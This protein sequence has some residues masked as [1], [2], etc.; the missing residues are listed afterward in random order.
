MGAKPV[1]TSFTSGVINPSQL[2]SNLDI[3]AEAIADSL[4]RTGGRKN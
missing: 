2:N 1:V 3:L 4:N